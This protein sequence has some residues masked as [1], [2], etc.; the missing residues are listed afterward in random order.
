LNLEENKIS[1]FVLTPPN[2]ILGILLIL[3]PLNFVFLGALVIL[4]VLGALNNLLNLTEEPKKTKV[5]IISQKKALD[6]ASQMQ[7][8]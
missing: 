6:M 7:V 5:A 4:G 1:S 3:G 2:A 8:V